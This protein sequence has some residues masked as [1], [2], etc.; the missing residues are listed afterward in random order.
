M[1]TIRSGNQTATQA[2][3]HRGRPTT[4]LGVAQ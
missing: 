4:Q 2:A 3:D 1:H